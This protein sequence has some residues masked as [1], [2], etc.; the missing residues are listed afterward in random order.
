MAP[1]SYQVVNVIIVD[2]SLRG[3]TCLLSNENRNLTTLRLTQR[4]SYGFKSV[5]STSDVYAQHPELWPF[6]KFFLPYHSKNSQSLPKPVLAGEN[7]QALKI[8]SIFVYNDPRDWGLDLAIIVDC[9][10][11]KNGQIGTISAKNGNE[12]LPNRGYQQDGQPE[13]FFSNPDL[14]FAAEFALPRLGQGGFR[15]A[16]EGIWADITGGPSAGVELQRRTFGKPH[17]ETYKYAEK[18]LEARRASL[19]GEDATQSPLK[20]VVM[21][22]DNPGTLYISNTDK[23]HLTD[24]LTESDIKGASS[25][26]SNRGI[27]WMSALVKSGIYTGGEPAC[28]PTSIVKD[29][30]EAVQWGI[31]QSR[32]PC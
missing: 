19:L 15:A 14:W 25:F 32:L 5:I 20:Q 1:R 24:P 11:S 26:R 16:L 22:G 8:D 13:L 6:S 9:L 4:Y 23:Y 2:R 17:Q 7:D 10:L 29:V 21:V 28:Q 30:S 31:Q 3:K 18:K 27:K 12:K